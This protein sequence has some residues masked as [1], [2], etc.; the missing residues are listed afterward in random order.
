MSGQERFETVAGCKIRLLRGGNGA[1]LLYLHGARGG[2]VWLP[3]M[4]KL[5]AHF[6]VI[7]PEHPGFGA[8]TGAASPHWR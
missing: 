3:F 5:A 7:A 1:P 2:G 4:D 6:E 8:S